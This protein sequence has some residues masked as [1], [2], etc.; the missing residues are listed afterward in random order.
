MTNPMKGEMSLKLGKNEY[1]T[2]LTIDS[3]IRI[4]T[5]L[6]KGILA[7]TQKIGDAD[8]RVGD[9]RTVLLHALRGGGN[10]LS[11]K[12]VSEV[13]HVT[14]NKNLPETSRCEE[15]SSDVNADLLLI[16]TVEYGF[17]EQSEDNRLGD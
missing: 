2:R 11:E 5:E 3:I 7:I 15:V 6:D 16:D 17:Q 10:D 9:L 13:T 12:D 8:V 4:E 14:L 1:K